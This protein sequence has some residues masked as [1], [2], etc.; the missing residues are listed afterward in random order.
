MSTKENTEW[1]EAAY[2]NLE[3]ALAM[4]DVATAKA[5]IADTREYG[6]YTE[7]K[8]MERRLTSE[9]VTPDY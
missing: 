1:L 7:A 2:D 8:Q 5:I 6:F 4:E 3:T 9:Y